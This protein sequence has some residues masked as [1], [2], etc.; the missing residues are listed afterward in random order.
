MEISK[1]AMLPI[2]YN[3]RGTYGQSK[4]RIYFRIEDE[5]VMENFVNRRT[6][7]YN[8]Y[9]KLIPQALKQL[10]L[11]PE[12]ISNMKFSWSKKAGCTMC[13][14]SPGFIVEVGYNEK[15]NGNNVWVTI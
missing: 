13:P 11:S 2:R 1:V 12:Q 6:R 3:G 15:L 5:T 9:R 7:P 4:T 8:E 14:C 10:G